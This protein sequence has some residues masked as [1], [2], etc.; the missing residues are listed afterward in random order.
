[1]KVGLATGF[2]G[3]AGGSLGVESLASMLFVYLEN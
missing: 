3:G 1:M 2:G